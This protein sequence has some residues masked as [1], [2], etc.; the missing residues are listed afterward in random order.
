MCEAMGSFLVGR[1]CSRE[2]H[3][4]EEGELHGCLKGDFTVVTSIWREKILGP[5]Y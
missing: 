2:E 4:E 5:L 1:V 3:W